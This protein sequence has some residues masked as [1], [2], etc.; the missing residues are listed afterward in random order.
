[1][2]S[3]ILV[4]SNLQILYRRDEDAGI[5]T[6]GA[7]RFQQQLHLASFQSGENGFDQL[8]GCRWRLVVIAHPQ[9]SAHVEM[10]QV[11]AHGS[12]SVDQQEDTVD[13]VQIG[14]DAG[15]LRS[16]VAIHADDV[17][18]GQAHSPLVHRYG[19]FNI[20]AELVFLEAG[21]NVGVRARIDVRVYP[22]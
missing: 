11:D 5:G 10:V 22:Q 6:D 13:S 12:Q 9:T 4:T 20:D 3:K 15:Q 7:A 19:A 18:V 16:D 1:H 2:D 14:G 21:R 8:L 17:D